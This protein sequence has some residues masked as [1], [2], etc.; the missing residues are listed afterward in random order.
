[1]IHGLTEYEK[2]QVIR[3]LW[4]RHKLDRFFF[5]IIHKP[6]KVIDWEN[7]TATSFKNLSPRKNNRNTL[8]LMFSFDKQLLSLWNN[9]LK[10]IP[11]FQ[12]CAAIGTPDFSAYPTM[13]PNDIQHNVYMSRWL[14]CTWQ[15]Y[16]CNVLPTVGW[17]G[18][19]TIDICLGGIEP[20]TPVVISTIGCNEHQED[21]LWGF[22]EMKARLDP[23]VIVVYGD[24][25]QGMTGTFLNIKYCD[26]FEK[27]AQQ[28]RMEII[29][30]LITIKEA[31]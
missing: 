31:I 2:Y 20:G 3:P 29:S 17:A 25:L 28:L 19:D 16:G 4:G 27:K 5:P 15:D 11:L 8:A 30:N 14:G 9:P 10:M 21:F 12:T 1:M 23:P 7:L 6:E 26:A 22:N 18:R 24:M 13:N